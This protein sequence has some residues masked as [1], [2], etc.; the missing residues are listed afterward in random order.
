MELC[1]QKLQFAFGA[2]LI[3]LP[4][5]CVAAWQRGHQHQATTL[6]S[7]HIPALSPGHQLRNTQTPGQGWLCFACGSFIPQTA[8]FYS[9]FL[10]CCLALEALQKLLCLRCAL[11]KTEEFPPCPVKG[12]A[13]SASPLDIVAM[14]TEQEPAEEINSAHKE[15]RISG[16]PKE[17]L[18]FLKCKHV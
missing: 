16:L 2:W 9:V 17:I 3:A 15:Q 14:C 8:S 6:G 1:I 10:V 5:E 18:T 4:V 11:C 13:L 12:R 7:S